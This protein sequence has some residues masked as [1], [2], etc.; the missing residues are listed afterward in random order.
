LAACFRGEIDGDLAAFPRF[1]GGQGVVEGVAVAETVDQVPEFF[2]G[3]G[4][5]QHLAAGCGGDFVHA[6]AVPGLV[7]IFAGAAGDAD[8][9]D[10]GGA[11][12]HAEGQAA[13]DEVESP[14]VVDDL[15]EG[16]AGFMTAVVGDGEEGAAARGGGVWLEGLGGGVDGVAEG[17]GAREVELEEALF[18]GLANEIEIGGEREEGEEFAGEGEDSDAITGAK[19]GEG[20]AGAGGDALDAGLHAAADIKEENEV[21]GDLIA[22][23]VADGLWL[24]VVVEE[25]V[26]GI[27]GGGVAGLAGDVDV[28]ADEADAPAED[29]WRLLG[30]EGDRREQPE[31][32]QGLGHTISI[33]VGGVG[34]L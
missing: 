6:G 1:S 25:E 4:C 13:D 26:L 12:G 24:A 31:G 30:G 11:A 17:G 20:G 19:F 22:G 18:D 2:V 21:E 10:A 29:G 3:L 14:E 27:K 15:F 8:G 33:A 7:D 28:D 23:E 16:G 32:W 9:E 5:V 34:I